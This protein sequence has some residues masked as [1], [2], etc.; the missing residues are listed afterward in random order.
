MTMNGPLLLCSL[1]LAS[2]PVA[3]SAQAPTPAPPPAPVPAATPVPLPT[4]APE[5]QK[6]AFLVGD[7]LHEETFQPG[8][9]SPGGTGKGRSKS[10][11]ALGDHFVYIIYTTNTPMGKLEARGFV[12]WDGE[13]KAYAMSWFD[14]MGLASHYTGSFDAAGALVMNAEYVSQGTPVKE[15]F[16][17]A[18]Q[19]DG[20]LLMTSAIAGPDG[21]FKT[22]MESV[23]TPATK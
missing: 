21:A 1:V 10:V 9:S 13:K 20:K 15:R 18:K 16:T 23:G 6:L 11:M 4:P 12:G 8:P 19:A 14:N 2:L 3:V 5:V 7:W 17:V 22:M